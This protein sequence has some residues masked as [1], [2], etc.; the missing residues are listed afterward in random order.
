M[1]NN[2]KEHE[3]GKRVSEKWRIDREEVEKA[4]GIYGIT[5]MLKYGGVAVE[6]MFLIC[7]RACRHRELSDE[8]K[9]GVI[10]SKQKD[11]GSKNECNN[12]REIS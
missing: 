10:V 2:S 4:A 5:S 11:K 6:W 9:K 3:Y 8:W 7:D 1:K 12:F